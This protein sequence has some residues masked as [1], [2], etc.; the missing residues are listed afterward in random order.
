MRAYGTGIEERD[1][2]PKPQFISERKSKRIHLLEKEAKEL[3]WQ[4]SFKGG[5]LSGTPTNY[6]LWYVG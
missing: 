6:H 3:R 1:D 5:P 2:L 4:D